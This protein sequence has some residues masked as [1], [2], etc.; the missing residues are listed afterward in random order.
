MQSSKNDALS[1]QPNHPPVKA[2]D[3]LKITNALVD[4]GQLL[5]SNHSLT[6]CFDIASQRSPCLS[7]GQL[8][9]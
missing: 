3:V 2:A 7:L 5:W 1:C 4:T 6:A 9:D 8:K